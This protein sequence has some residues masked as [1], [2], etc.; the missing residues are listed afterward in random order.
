[1]SFAG[2]TGSSGD[3][4]QL[5]SDIEAAGC[6]KREGFQNFEKENRQLEHL[7]ADLTVDD[8][9][10]RG[11]LTNT[12]GPAGRRQA[13]LAMVEAFGLSGG[14]PVGP[15]ERWRSTSRLVRFN[16][17]GSPRVGYKISE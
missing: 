8:R 4:L 2:A 9:A 6:R 15:V 10:L 12:L 13:A 7:V 5:A 11:A 16:R 1:M 17:A 3:L 14:G